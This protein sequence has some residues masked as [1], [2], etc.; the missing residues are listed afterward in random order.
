MLFLVSCI[1]QVL[2]RFDNVYNHKM[3]KWT[4]V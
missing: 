1:L 3:G 4:A 2:S